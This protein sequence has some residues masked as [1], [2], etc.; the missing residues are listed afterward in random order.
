[1]RL[2]LGSGDLHLD[3][4]VNVDLREDVA[5]VVCDATDLSRWA[6]GAAFEIKATDLL[7]HF[8]ASRTDAILAEWARVLCPGGRLI[9]KVPNVEALA[10]V[11]VR[12]SHAGERNDRAVAV[13]IKNLYGGHRWGPDGAWDTHHTGWTPR[14]LTAVLDRAGFDVVSV[15]GELNMTVEA[16]KR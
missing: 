12:M 2:N 14:L 7:E 13:C 8:P 9:L 16:K 5:D 3:G 11:I 6:D 15:D 10:E 1:M 4:Y